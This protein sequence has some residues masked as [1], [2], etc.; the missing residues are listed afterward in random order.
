MMKSFEVKF[1][2][3]DGNIYVQRLCC[4]DLALSHVI[5]AAWKSLYEGKHVA[6]TALV[7][8]IHEVDAI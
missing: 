7:D 5:R 8:S 6:A 2:D 4:R 1:V 3:R